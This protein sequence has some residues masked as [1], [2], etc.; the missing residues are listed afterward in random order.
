MH[1][2]VK[3]YELMAIDVQGTNLSSSRAHLLRP[4]NKLLKSFKKII[5][6]LSYS[7]SFIKNHIHYT[8]IKSISSRQN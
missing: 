3:N 4:K 8:L 5:T 1:N 7:I 2:I 6:L